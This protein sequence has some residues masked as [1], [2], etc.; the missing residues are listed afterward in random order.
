M[1]RT[2]EEWIAYYDQHAEV[3][4]DD[5]LDECDEQFGVDVDSLESATDLP[6]AYFITA[7]R[8]YAARM[9]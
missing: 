9:A 3:I 6:D 2:N 5:I 8:K 4:D 1:T 7:A